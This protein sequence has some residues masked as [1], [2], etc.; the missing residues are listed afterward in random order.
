MNITKSLMLG[1]VAASLSISQTINI[2][3]TVK[4]QSGT[5]ITGAAVKLEKGG[6]TATTGSGG[7]FTLTTTGIISSQTV[8]PKLLSGI[9][10]G[11]LHI[12]VADKTPL[13]II[14]YTLQGKA[15]SRIQKSVAA[16][17]HSIAL[18][19]TG[20]GVYLYKIRSAGGEVL[21]KGHSFGG[22]QSGWLTAVASTTSHENA[23]LTRGYVP[24]NDVIAVIKDG[25]LNYRVIVT[26]SDTSGI[27]I[28]MIQNAGNVTDA[29]G[30]VYQSVK[31]GTQTWT[32]ENLRTKKY[33]DN[34]VIQQVTD[35]ASWN[36]LTTPAYC[37]YGNTTQADS[38]KKYG[39]LYNF[40]AVTDAKK[41]A[42]TG[43]H[44]PTDLEWDTLQNYLIAN[45]YN[46]DATTSGNKV[47]KSMATKAD[48]SANTT[49]GAIGNDLR[50]NNKS[51]FTALPGGSR[52]QSGTFVNYLTGGSWWSATEASGNDAYAR[53]LVNNAEGLAKGNNPKIFGVSVRLLKDNIVINDKSFI[54]SHYDDGLLPNDAYYFRDSLVKMGYKLAADEVTPPIAKIK[55][56]LETPVWFYYHTGHGSR[57][58]QIKAKDGQYVYNM[59]MVA[60]ENFWTATCHT[61]AETGW[62]NQMG[63][64][65]KNILG[66]TDWTFDGTQFDDLAVKNFIIN[67]RKYPTKSMA[68]VMYQANWF[69][70]NL[71][72]K[73]AD[74]SRTS[75]GIVEYGS[76]TNLY[77][78]DY[79]NL[80]YGD[81]PG[82][83]KCKVNKRILED[84]AV[85]KNFNDLRADISRGITSEGEISDF[86]DLPRSTTI[87]KDEAVAA[88]KAHLALPQDAVFEKVLSLEARHENKAKPEVLGYQIIFS[89]VIDGLPVKGTFFMDQISCFVDNNKKL[90]YVYK[91][92]PEYTV[93]KARNSSVLSVKDA[94]I[95]ALPSISRAYKGDVLE[96]VDAYPVYGRADKDTPVLFGAY[97]FITSKGDAIIVDAATGEIR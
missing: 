28:G 46:W 71:N 33:A 58:G 37:Y 41:L 69:D 3:G 62:K 65:C 32:V 14:T 22:L 75:T 49:S 97:A 88:A 57:G 18:S 64:T 25:Y 74:Y 23:T 96:I 54:V 30:N 35:S 89:R 50:S 91:Y 43:W 79:S 29:D 24:I 7:S 44:I 77:P 4:N 38:I 94:V 80:E 87:T 70:P 73:W 20:T 95:K 53:S 21:L 45:G 39:A 55:A 56:F 63:P 78:T 6:Q 81:V 16:G 93:S 2:S 92:W 67:F 11:Q 5:G 47:A 61:G 34:S 8:L 52:V 60:A 83:E 82:A 51:G 84:E 72:S 10:H 13:E 17:N 1:I 12:C 27:E 42:P 86:D 15:I 59:T 26:N 66:Y 9:Y 48:W 68:Y 85:Y 90:S 31:I 76:R 19:R 36:T 40:Y